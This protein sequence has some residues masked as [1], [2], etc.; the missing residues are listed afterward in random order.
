MAL[1]TVLTMEMALALVLIILITV[2][3]IMDLLRLLLTMAILSL[4]LEAI[5][6]LPNVL[7]ALVILTMAIPHHHHLITGMDITGL[8]T[9]SPSMV[10]RKVSALRDTRAIHHHRRHL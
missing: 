4:F 2:L 1:I 8:T 10:L 3:L 9:T 7:P 6:L 5:L